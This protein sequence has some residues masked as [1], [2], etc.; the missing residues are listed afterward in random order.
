MEE[1]EEGS[2]DEAIVNYC[3]ERVSQEGVGW[4]MSDFVARSE[5]IELKFNESVEDNGGKRGV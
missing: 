2:L 5:A 1:I 4:R 3:E